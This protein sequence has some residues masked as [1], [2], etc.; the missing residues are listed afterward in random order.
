MTT[1]FQQSGSSIDPS[2]APVIVAGIRV[3]TAALAGENIK[4]VTWSVSTTPCDLCILFLSHCIVII[5][6]IDI[7][8]I[9][10]FVLRYASRRHLFVFSTVMI[11][12]STLT[13]ATFSYLRTSA[14]CLDPATLGSP[15]LGLVPLLAVIA[16]FVGHAL[17]VVPVCQLLAAEV[18]P[19]H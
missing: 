12:V 19:P 11:A 8:L 14:C 7:P 18:N 6:N 4:H 17:G 9:A 13:I 3:V 5:L 10:A 16:M 2:L 15:Q 1:I